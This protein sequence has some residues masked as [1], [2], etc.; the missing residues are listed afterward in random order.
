MNFD[1]VVGCDYLFL[2]VSRIDTY[3]K[4]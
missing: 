2:A 3:S 1:S 4:G